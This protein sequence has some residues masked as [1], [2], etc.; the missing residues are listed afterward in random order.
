MNNS[1]ILT[2]VKRRNGAR[3]PRSNASFEKDWNRFFF[4]SRHGS[5]AIFRSD[6]FVPC[7]R[8]ENPALTGTFS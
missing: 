5:E 1:S 3:L 8:Y 6:G 4:R 7:F 2:G